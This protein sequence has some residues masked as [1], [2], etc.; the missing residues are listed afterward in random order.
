MR[1]ATQG[2]GGTLA[3]RQDAAAATTTLLKLDAVH[4]DEVP[5]TTEN[6]KILRF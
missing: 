5:D 2:I 6:R 4:V 3:R 1:A